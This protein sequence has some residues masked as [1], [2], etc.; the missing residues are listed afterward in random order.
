MGQ[1]FNKSPFLG[2][3]PRKSSH[4]PVLTMT[5][6]G[7]RSRRVATSSEHARWREAASEKL[8]RM[9]G[10]GWQDVRVPLGQIILGRE[11]GFGR[12]LG[13]VVVGFDRV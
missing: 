10:R 2:L 3:A 8:W 5:G 11:G 7:G 4:S 12:C 9:R 13:Q 6:R 1:C